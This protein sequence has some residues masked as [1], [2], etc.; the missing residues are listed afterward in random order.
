[1]YLDHFYAFELQLQKG[2]NKKNKK[3]CA[4]MLLWHDPCVWSLV[5]ALD[6]LLL[7]ND[8]FL[9]QQS[10][11]SLSKQDISFTVANSKVQCGLCVNWEIENWKMLAK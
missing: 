3:H 4:Y 10:E 6:V 8:L 5:F 9:F 1:M 11:I 2:A 7:L